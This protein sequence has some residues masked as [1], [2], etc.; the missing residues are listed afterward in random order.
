MSGTLSFAPFLN[1]MSQVAR[2]PLHTQQPESA[3]S[4][5]EEQAQQLVKEHLWYLPKAKDGSA[6]HW[7]L[8]PLGQQNGT[9][10]FQLRFVPYL[11][12]N[13]RVGGTISVSPDGTV[14]S[15]FLQ[16][17]ILQRLEES[18][19]DVRY[20]I[21]VTVSNYLKIKPASRLGYGQRHS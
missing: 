12:K 8:E 21:H 9:W 13:D 10:A 18:L 20:A 7:K 3:E 2:L 1:R 15:K 17:N 19:T 6:K 16:Q 4:L 5:S 14:T 11:Q